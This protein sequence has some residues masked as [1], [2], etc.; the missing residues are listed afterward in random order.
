MSDQDS[1]GNRGFVEQQRKRLEALRK[2]L[3]GMEASQDTRARVFRK[4]HGGEA[5][6]FEDEAQNM[7][8]NEIDEAIHR[9]D[10]RRL[11]AID[12]ALAKI[13]E[14]TYGLSDMSGK[15]IPKARLEATPEAVLTV[16]E[17]DQREMQQ[18]R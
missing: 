18:R 10:E 12:R 16:E 3:S 9:V 6:E 14:G 8:E 5:K 4:E 2:Q 15:P 7:A 17:E 11:R 1:T 13:G